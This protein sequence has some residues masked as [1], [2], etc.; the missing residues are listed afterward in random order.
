[1]AMHAHPL[2]TYP[3]APT[4]PITNTATGEERVVHPSPLI[5][6]RIPMF[7]PVIAVNNTVLKV[8]S[9][10]GNSGR[11][12]GAQRGRKSWDGGRDAEAEMEGVEEGLSTS[13]RLGSSRAP[14]RTRSKKAD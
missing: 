11:V 1:M 12:A 14:L 9:G 8:L 4:P 7:A 3:Y 10:L 2:P 13:R 5:P 6:V